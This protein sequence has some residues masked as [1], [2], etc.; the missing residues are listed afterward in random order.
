[1]PPEPMPWPMLVVWLAFWLYGLWPALYPEYFRKVN[2]RYTPRWA[3]IVFLVRERHR[4]VAFP[5]LI[6]TAVALVAGVY[7]RL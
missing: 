7:S 2:L 1:M 4:A 3:G 6:L 5:W